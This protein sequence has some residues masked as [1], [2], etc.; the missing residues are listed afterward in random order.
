[1]YIIKSV[2]LYL[3]RRSGFYIK[4]YYI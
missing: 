3:S 2:N 1:M 4:R